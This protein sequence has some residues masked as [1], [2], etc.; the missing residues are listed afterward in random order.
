MS[1]L[2]TR[3]ERALAKTLASPIPPLLTIQVPAQTM[4]APTREAKAEAALL[5]RAMGRVWA[6]RGDA[7][8]EGPSPSAQRRE[9]TRQLLTLVKTKPEV[10]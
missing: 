4:P 5:M 7:D 6:L 3:V 10:Y 9:T 1:T 8:G 2:R